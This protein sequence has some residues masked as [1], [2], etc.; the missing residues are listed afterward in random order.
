M[1]SQAAKLSRVNEG[2]VVANV[3]K[4][5]SPDAQATSRG[6]LEQAA[7]TSALRTSLIYVKHDASGT[8]NGTSWANAYTDLQDAL[9]AAQSGNE[10]WVAAGTYKPTSGNN[11]EVFFQLKN[12]V[13]IYGGL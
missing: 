5:T 2:Q 13:A 8:N 9:A 6:D 3:A 10:I 11:R 4:L 12:G 1:T 7:T